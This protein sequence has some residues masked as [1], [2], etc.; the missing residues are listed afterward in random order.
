MWSAKNHHVTRL[1]LPNMLNCLGLSMPTL[2]GT[3]THSDVLS[4]IYT[5]MKAKH[6]HEQNDL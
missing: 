4:C 1:N 3:D 2:L 5:N 6:E